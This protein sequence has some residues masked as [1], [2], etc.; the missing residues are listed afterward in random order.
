MKLNTNSATTTTTTT[1]TTLLLILTLLL[2]NNVL[3]FSFY[4]DNFWTYL[5]LGLEFWKLLP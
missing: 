5:R 2:F 1:T 3:T 4:L